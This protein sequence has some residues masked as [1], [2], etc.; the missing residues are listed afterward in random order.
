MMNHLSLG[1]NHLSCG[2]ARNFLS[3]RIHGEPLARRRWVLVRVQPSPMSL[4]E[5][6]SVRLRQARSQ[7]SPRLTQAQLAEKV[8]IARSAYERIESGKGLPRADTLQRLSRVLD[9]SADWLLGNQDQPRVLLPGWYLIDI[10][11]IQAVLATTCPETIREL[12]NQRLGS[13]VDYAT[14]IP[15]DVEVMDAGATLNL[16]R[17]FVAHIATHAT[18]ELKD[19]FAKHLRENGEQ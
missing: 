17:Q 8:G 4:S 16:E 18:G 13:P 1:V 12:C 2:A 10:K 15:P 6:I 5:T 11:L 9:V 3:M 19:I 14:P 7:A